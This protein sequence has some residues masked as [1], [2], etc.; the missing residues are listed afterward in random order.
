V[1]DFV[2]TVDELG[3]AVDRAVVAEELRARIDAIAAQLHVTTQTVLRNYL[4]E[5]WG[6]EMAETMMAEVQTRNAV[7]TGPPEHFAVRVVGRLVAALEQAM[8]YATVNQDAQ[9]PI[10][11]MDLQ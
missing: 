7:P 3:G 6:R 5:G 11:A 8:F 2:A 1:E 9:Q 4:D 10:P